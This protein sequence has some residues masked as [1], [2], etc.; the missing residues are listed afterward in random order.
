MIA[1]HA[2]AERF[3]RF[4]PRPT[5]FSLSEQDAR[6]WHRTG[7]GE[8]HT[9]LTKYIGGK[10]AHKHEWGEVAKQVW[11]D[12]SPIYSMFDVKVGEFETDE[13][14]RFIELLKAAEF[15]AVFIDD[16]NPHDFDKGGYTTSLCVF[17][18][19]KHVVIVKVVSW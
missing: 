5:W 17:D 3:K 12:T 10:I 11:P 15:D 6:G 16:Y 19:S 1:Y 18:P 8:Q 2:T 9:Y 13:I 14:K 4:L 7:Y